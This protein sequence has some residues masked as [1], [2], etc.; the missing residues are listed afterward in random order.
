MDRRLGRFDVSE[1]AL[2]SGAAHDALKRTDV[3][4]VEY[5]PDIG[6]YRFLAISPDFD[7]VEEGMKAPFYW[8]EVERIAL[9]RR[10]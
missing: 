10:V 4:S 1:E 3:L 9:F 8:V 7:P 6:V 2:I 5:H